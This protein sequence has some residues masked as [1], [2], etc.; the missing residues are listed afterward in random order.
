MRQEVFVKIQPY[1][2]KMVA[3][4]VMIITEPILMVLLNKSGMINDDR[5]SLL[6]LA[7]IMMINI[8]LI[9]DAKVTWRTI[10]MD[11]EGCTIRLLMFHRIYKWEEIRIK[12]IE[13]G[14]ISRS[15]PMQGVFFSVDLRR[16]QERM[17]PQLYCALHNPFRCFFIYFVDEN[18]KKSHHPMGVS[19]KEF[20]EKMDQW[21]V[22]LSMGRH[23]LNDQQLFS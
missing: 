13:S 22:E 19:R 20:F 10:I 2:E 16:K 14:Y 9:L 1:Y 8:L 23:A 12:R 15:R 18:I 4:I 21:N 11:E 6:F 7:F 17:D 3:A 5:T